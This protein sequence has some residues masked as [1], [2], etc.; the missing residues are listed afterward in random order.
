[1]PKFLRTAALLTAV[2]ALP[3]CFIPSGGGGGTTPT[4]AELA[5]VAPGSN[6]ALIIRNS[7]QRTICYVN[8]SPASSSSWGQDQLGSSETISPGTIR[9]W[10]VP[11]DTYDLRVLDCNRNALADDRGV[12]VSGQGIVV[13]YQ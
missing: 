4:S 11:P 1:M 13:T 12:A 3:A 6:P 9:G 10:R 7:S 2:F 8:F 5:S